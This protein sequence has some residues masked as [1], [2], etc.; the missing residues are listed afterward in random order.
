M[1]FE[2]D[3]N[4]NNSVFKRINRVFE[5]LPLAAVVANKIFCV[6]SGIGGTL[7]SID[8]IK[9]I[10]RP[11][12]INY[13]G[14]TKEQ[15]IVLD[16]LWS[17]P[18]LND[19]ENSNRI[20]ENRDMI[21][22]GHIVRYGV[23]RI[24]QFMSDNKMQVM[25]RSHECVMDGVEKFGNTNLYTVFSCT[26]YGG[27]YSNKA[28]LLLVKK[29]RLEVVSKWIDCIPDSTYWFNLASLN[30]KP[31]QIDNTTQNQK[32]AGNEED[33]LR[34]RPITPPRRMNMKK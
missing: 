23:D 24:R 18:V 9:S 29:N 30:K 34:N 33:S 13:D 20:N 32:K 17:D 10:K 1:R 28:A 22:S 11:L 27:K 16:L 2:E 31:A 4:D 25:I 8:E 26:E 6:H 12:E 5:Y 15:K 14:S 7:K 3:I 21:A 19:S